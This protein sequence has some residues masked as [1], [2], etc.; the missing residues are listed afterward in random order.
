VLGGIANVINLYTE[1]G[2]PILVQAHTYIGFTGTMGAANRE[3][4]LNP[5]SIS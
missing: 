3:K 4:L 5:I 1:P 2:D